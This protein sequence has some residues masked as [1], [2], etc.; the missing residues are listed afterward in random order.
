MLDLASSKAVYREVLVKIDTYFYTNPDWKNLVKNGFWQLQLAIQN[1]EF[2]TFYKLSMNSER[3]FAF[4][5]QID[6][7]LHRQNVRN[8]Q[9]VLYAAEYISRQANQKYGLPHQSSMLEMTSG[10]ISLL[11]RYSSYLTGTELNDMFSQINGNFV[12]L[13][14]EL[15]ILD[16]CLLIDR[17]IQGGPAGES[18]IK[19]GDRIIEV[20]RQIIPQ[21]ASAKAADLLKGM[22][23][24]KVEIV[25]VGGDGS[26]R[27]LMLT[28]RRV[29]VPS[30][31]DIKMLD[32]KAG[33]GY[34]RIRSFQKNT[35]ADV[36]KALW[37]LHNQ[38]MSRLVVDLRSN[39]G[40]LVDS[41]VAVADFF[42]DDES[43]AVWDCCNGCGW[44]GVPVWRCRRK[45]PLF[46]HAVLGP[47]ILT[48][49]RLPSHPSHPLHWALAQPARASQA[50]DRHAF[51]CPCSS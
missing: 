15:R 39:P 14:V 34:L 37:D 23:D 42:I 26:V 1:K 46:L 11:D 6:N 43:G 20:D 38:G 19:K 35:A 32:V 2:C 45:L 41:A 27:R 8:Y 12:G 30:V 44:K 29:V 13:G 49:P 17:V 16:K 33:V 36:E 50:S 47:R 24:S 22:Q 28:R 9:D 7:W 48:I 5:K 21:I 31:E 40:G 18:G 3:D 4:K 51:D 10:S 25:V